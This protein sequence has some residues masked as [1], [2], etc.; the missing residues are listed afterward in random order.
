MLKI[1]FFKSVL[2]FLLKCFLPE[3]DCF[4][5]FRPDLLMNACLNILVE[6][7]WTSTSLISAKSRSK[8]IQISRSVSIYICFMFRNIFRNLYVHKL[9]NLYESAAPPLAK[10]SIFADFILK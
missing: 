6:I 8:C 4:A 1:C 7:H 9:I 3:V 10:C 5:N 2:Q